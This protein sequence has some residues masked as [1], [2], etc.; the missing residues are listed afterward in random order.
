MRRRTGTAEPAALTP[1][2]R[3][4]IVVSAVIIMMGLMTFVRVTHSRRVSTESAAPRHHGCDRR[5]DHPGRRRLLLSPDRIP[6]DSWSTGNGYPANGVE[7]HYAAAP[8]R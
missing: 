2:R 8:R 4:I 6:K 7:S 1:A 5:F 3:G